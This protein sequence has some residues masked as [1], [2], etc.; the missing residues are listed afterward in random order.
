MPTRLRLR[1]F[2]LSSG[3]ADIGICAG[4]L[5]ACAEI[6]NAAQERLLTAKECNE[7]GWWGGWAEIVFSVEKC[8]PY[9]TLPR[10]VARL[11]AIDICARPVPLNNQFY[12]YLQFGDGRMPKAGFERGQWR[13]GNAQGYERNMAVTF[14][15]L[16]DGPQYIQVYATNPADYGKRAFIQGL[17]QNNQ[18]IYTQDGASRVMG[19]FVTLKSPYVSTVNTFNRLTGLQKD[20]TASEVQFFQVDPNWGSMEQLSQMEPGET[21]AWYRRYYLSNIPARC[22]KFERAV[23]SSASA[24]CGCPYQRKEHVLVTA[25]VKLDLVPA[26]YDTD[27]LLLQSLEA[28]KRET[29]SIRFSKMDDPAAQQ[30]SAEHHQAA[31]RL[32][33]GQLTH[34]QGKN[35]VA[36]NFAP[37]GNARLERLNIG[38]R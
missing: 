5:P 11:E 4:N 36:V 6:V 17:D 1:D 28:I 8:K 27:Y 30:T 12:E 10:D 15:D 31:I 13:W 26:V 7:T 25:L 19:E 21:T 24:Q 16:S 37:F 18:Q 9:I 14:T 29:Q 3:P 38:M 23:P 20:V 33:I 22:C 2:R 35:N 34:F 32:L